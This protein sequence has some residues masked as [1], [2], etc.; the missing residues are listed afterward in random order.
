MRRVLSPWSRTEVGVQ[1]PN[2]QQ[3]VTIRVRPQDTIKLLR[4]HLVRQGVTSWK[5]NFTYNGRELGENETLEGNRIGSGAVL[6]LVKESRPPSSA[7]RCL[8]HQLALQ[9]E[10]QPYYNVR[11]ELIV[12]NGLLLRQRYLPSLAWL[13]PR[14]SLFAKQWNSEKI[15]RSLHHRGVT[16]TGHSAHHANAELQASISINLSYQHGLGLLYQMNQLAS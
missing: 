4:L 1:L 7:C 16:Q 12:V 11:A 2:E 8:L 3:L 5:M 14:F 13:I 15:Q 9:G 6:V 10:C